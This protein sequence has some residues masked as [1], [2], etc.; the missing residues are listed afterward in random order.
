MSQL[1]LYAT[2]DGKSQIQLRADSGT[3]WL[4]QLE[5]AE[6]FQTSKQNIAKHLKVI[7]TEQELVQDSVVNQRLTTAADGKNYRARSPRGVQFRRWASTVLKEYL[8]K[9][10]LMNDERLQNPYDRP[11]Y[12]DEMLA[13]I[14]DIQASERRFYQKVR[15]LFAPQTMTL[16]KRFTFTAKDTPWS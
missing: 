9:G 11:H 5:I 10:F 14:R 8:V 7:F 2:D 4:T 16:Q 3:V 12:L 1:V 15:D 6:L 13:R